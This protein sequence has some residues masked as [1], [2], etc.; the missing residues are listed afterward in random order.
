MLKSEFNFELPKELIAQMPPE[1]RGRSR[2]LVVHRETGTWEHRSFLDLP[3]YLNPGDLLVVNDS[4]VIPARLYGHNEKTGGFIELLL[5]ERVE[6]TR[7][8]AM[9]HP[10]RR[11]RMG[12]KLTFGNGKL[13]GEVVPSRDEYYRE[14]EFAYEGTW[15]SILAELGAMPVPPYIKRSPEMKDLLEMDRD[16]YQTV[17]AKDEGSIAA[18]TAGLHFTEELLESLKAKGIPIAR[19]TLHVGTGTFLPVKTDNI[20]DHP[21]HEE[22]FTLSPETVEAIH[23]THAAGKRVIAVGTTSTRVLESVADDLGHLK[24]VTS[25]TRIFIYPGYKFKVV[26]ALITN[27]HLPESTLVMLVS[28]L[29][30]KETIFKAYQ[31]AIS[32]KYRF[33]SYGD[34]MLII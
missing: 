3:N 34:A 17:Y 13:K 30:G 9:V 31:E 6:E 22:K 24:P 11:C 12:M 33:Y 5:I 15:E 1:T 21:M 27:F 7:W 2:L 20:E 4:K 16:R 14:I 29:A 28:A 23:Q 10:G 18:P 32:Q 19:V 8:L 25:S 26:D